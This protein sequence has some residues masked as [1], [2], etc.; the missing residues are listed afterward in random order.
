MATN[1]CYAYAS[2]PLGSGISWPLSFA[3]SNHSSITTSEFW[4][5]SFKLSRTSILIQRQLHVIYCKTYKSYNNKYIIF[6]CILYIISHYFSCIIP[7]PNNNTRTEAQ[8]YDLIYTNY[9]FSG[10]SNE[11]DF[12]IKYG[13]KDRREEL[14]YIIK[15]Y[16]DKKKIQIFVSMKTV[17]LEILSLKMEMIELKYLCISINF[18]VHGYHIPLNAISNGLNVG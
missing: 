1:N 3:T 16:G 15:R 5:A 2:L 7:I 10:I 13:T 8:K 9:L 14:Q 4:T 6:S 18:N 17:S 12:E 11:I